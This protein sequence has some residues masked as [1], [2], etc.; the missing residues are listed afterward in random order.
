MA[1]SAVHS[2][3]CLPSPASSLPRPSPL[4][5][6]S[7]FRAQVGAYS[8]RSVARRRLL[9]NGDVHLHVHLHFRL[10]RALR[11]RP[12]LLRS[13]A[14]FSN[15]GSKWEVE[16]LISSTTLFALITTIRPTRE[17]VARLASCTSTLKGIIHAHT[18]PSQIKLKLVGV[19]SAGRSDVRVCRGCFERGVP[20]PL[21]SGLAAPSCF[22]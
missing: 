8:L 10:A 7:V 15:S 12:A 19:D 16:P 6:P 22:H 1:G 9:V 20:V 3:P 4:S 14:A 18:S 17:L 11:C 5:N 21:D 2:H 13:L